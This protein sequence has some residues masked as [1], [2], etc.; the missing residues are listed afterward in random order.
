MTN[1]KT[2]AKLFVVVMGLSLLLLMALFVNYIRWSLSATGEPDHDGMMRA[3]AKL[4]F[5]DAPFAV[6]GNNPRKIL[7]KS[8]VGYKRNLDFYMVTRGWRPVEPIEMGAAS[9]Y[10]KNGK[11]VQTHSKPF[12]G[13]FRLY[14]IGKEFN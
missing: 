5:T 14:R 12:T 3:A 10:G 11:S 13:K 9:Y 1:R 2:R 8:R 7:L 4:T 6:V